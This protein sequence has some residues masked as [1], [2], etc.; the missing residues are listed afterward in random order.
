MRTARS[1]WRPG[2]GDLHQAPPWTRPPG[3]RH[4]TGTR[5]PQGETHP[6]VNRITDTCKNITFPQLRL[7]AVMMKYDAIFFRAHPQ[8][9]IDFLHQSEFVL[10]SHSSLQ[11]LILY[12][13]WQSCK[14]LNLEPVFR[15]VQF[16]QNNNHSYL[17]SWEPV[18]LLGLWQLV[19]RW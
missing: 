6:P 15:E 17:S 3:T 5:P 18:Q 7:R 10:L 1:R 19:F 16:F 9:G 14:H 8:L 13:I 2:G 11:S 12:V 4:P